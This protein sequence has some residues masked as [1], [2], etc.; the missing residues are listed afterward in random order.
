MVKNNNILAIIQARMSSSRLPG[1]MLLPIYKNKSVLEFMFNR[2]KKSKKI[3]TIIVGTSIDKSDDA[4][5]H[6]CK[7]NNI[8]CYR[9]SLH[10]VLDRFYQATQAFKPISHVVRLTGDCP[11]H[12]PIV[13]DAVIEHA[14]STKADY[15]CNTNPPTFPDGLDCEVMTC[16]TLETTFNNATTSFEKEHVT[17]YIYQHP[18]KFNC[19]N[20]LAEQN[21][22]NYRFT[23]DETK[24][25]EFISN[26]VNALHDKKPT[27]T[28]QD[29]I[30]LLKNKPE[31][32]MLNKHIKRNKG[33]KK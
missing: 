17:P 9:G 6:V 14:L 27:F 3:D 1:K 33:S 5:E 26:V 15:T 32:I 21:F 19:E 29:V 7:K 18:E 8:N 4:I 31:W 11:I 20:M 16:D 30:H 25:L 10:N 23:L 12:D 13:I 2:V 24:D 28:F 22:S